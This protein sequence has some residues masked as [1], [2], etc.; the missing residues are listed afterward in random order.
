MTS[1]DTR[2]AHVLGDVIGSLVIDEGR[3]YA[4]RVKNELSLSGFSV[5]HVPA[6][7]VLVG[8]ALEDLYYDDDEEEVAA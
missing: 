6:Q 8:D 4:V 7:Y 5:L 2:P 1:T 3:V